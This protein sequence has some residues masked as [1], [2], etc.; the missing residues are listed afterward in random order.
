M[1]TRLKQ[2]LLTCLLSLGFIFAGFSTLLTPAPVY[3]LPED[4]SPDTIHDNN[5][6]RSDQTPGNEA[7]D[8]ETS[9]ST[10]S[11]PNPTD[12]TPTTD[13]TDDSENSDDPQKAENHGE[14]QTTNSNPEVNICQTEFG[15]VSWILCP[16]MQIVGG[17]VD[18]IYGLIENF[19]D[20]KSTLV[21]QDSAVHQVWQ[22]TRDITNTVFIIF[23][24][25]VVFS[26]LT[27]LGINNYGIKRVL[28]R[29][30]VAAILVNLSFYITALA[31]D[32]SNIIGSSISTTIQDLQIELAAKVPESDPFRDVSWGS[33]LAALTGGG[34]ILAVT[35]IA[36]SGVGALLWICGLAL[37]GGIISLGIGIVTICFRQGVVLILIMIAPLAFVCYLLPNTERWFDRWKNTLA[38]MIFFYPMFSFL[39]NASKLAGLA[40]IYSA[41]GSLFRVLLGLAIQVMPLC[42]SVPL[43]QMS[44]TVL[45]SISRGLNNLSNPARRAIDKWGLSHVDQNRQRYLEANRFPG[46]KLRNYLAERAKRREL[47]TKNLSSSYQG[48]LTENALKKIGSSTG[49]DAFGHATWRRRPNRLTSAAKRA[50]LQAT[51]TATAELDLKNTLSEYGD[52]FHGSRVKTLADAHAG[53][54][55]ETMAQ[56]F[57]AENIA[58]GDQSFLLDRYM[59]AAA[60]RYTAPYEFNRL[61]GGATGKL[62]HLGETTIMGQV[63]IRSADIERRRKAEAEIVATKFGYPKSQFRN[64]AFDKAAMNDDGYELDE[65]GEVIE[66][67]HYRLKKGKVHRPYQYYIGVHKTTNVEITKDEY[68]AL[69]DAERANY[70]KIKY[71]DLTDDHGNV[72]NRVYEDDAGY[73]KTFIARDVAIGDPINMRY[74]TE[75]GLARPDSEKTPIIEGI[76]T[77]DNLERDGTLRRFHSTFAAALQASRFKEKNAAFTTMLT[78]QLDNGYITSPGQLNIAMLDVITKSSKASDFLQN[79]RF[80]LEHFANLCRSLVATEEG[81]RFEDYFP[82]ESIANY[83]NVNGER[84]PGYRLSMD[85]DGN[86]VWNKISRNDKTLT[87]DD[88]RNYLKHNLFASF[89]KT[90]FDY[91][92]RRP[93]NNTLDAQKSS[94]TEA[95]DDFMSIM[96]NLGSDNLDVN[97]PF[98]DRLNPHVDVLKGKDP[99]TISSTYRNLVEQLYQTYNNSDSSQSSGSST[100]TSSP[101]KPKSHGTHFE[102]SSQ[103]YKELAKVFSKLANTKDFE[104]MYSVLDDSTSI[105]NNLRDVFEQVDDFDSITTAVRTAFKESDTLSSSPSAMSNLEEIITFT[106]SKLDPQN[107]DDPNLIRDFRDEVFQLIYTEYGDYGQN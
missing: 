72:M 1:K 80:S 18:Y 10:D 50:S 3:A 102:N 68:D 60:G 103:L 100:S 107:P 39:F 37:L 55:L 82:D 104:D 26:Q 71:L 29:I 85:D 62:G 28:P 47:N 81:Y 24:L 76:T 96:L 32:L 86:A 15:S 41:E 34:G 54:Y 87:L 16:V 98:L 89:V 21:D 73:M 35:V 77:A 40:I 57:R 99:N 75:L 25:I 101:S 67:Q 49:Y 65:N 23:I 46:S 52:I 12:E 22:K 105:T 74:A 64:M 92:K 90:L 91:G 42:L 2:L 58:Q 5:P 48:R 14:D 4:P 79:D 84:L 19:L 45:G 83:R 94:A 33:L 53:A 66:D 88:Q 56:Q 8:S 13:I 63:V 11:D 9:D 31:V 97:I 61:I 78:T 38:Q 27:G 7:V 95:L 6:D 69:S 44:N 70:K 93:S 36:N 17:G 59:K 51:R 30:I 106:E 20:V 43:L